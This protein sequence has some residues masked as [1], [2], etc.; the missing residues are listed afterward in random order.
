LIFSSCSESKRFL[1]WFVFSRHVPQEFFVLIFSR[2]VL[3]SKI[4][5]FDFLVPSLRANV[6]CFH[7]MCWTYNS[8]PF[9][10]KSKN[11]LT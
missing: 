1:F 3:Q 2:R 5:C 8:T 4:F 11:Q 6:F 7:V 9:I 10:F